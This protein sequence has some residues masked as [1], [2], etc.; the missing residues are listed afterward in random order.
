[1]ADAAATWLLQDDM[2]SYLGTGSAS[3]TVSDPRSHGFVE[4][5]GEVIGASSSSDLKILVGRTSSTVFIGCGFDEEPGS[6]TIEIEQETPNL[7]LASSPL[8]GA[9]VP[10]PFVVRVDSDPSSSN[11]NCSGIEGGKLTEV[12]VSAAS[13]T[14]GQVGVGLRG[15][16]VQIRYLIIIAHD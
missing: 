16:Q 7:V 8:M 3:F 12:T 11:I 13:L 9:L 6:S 15:V 5:G 2:V 1:L 4:I 14:P 10:G